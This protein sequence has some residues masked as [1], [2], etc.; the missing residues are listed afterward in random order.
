MRHLKPFFLITDTGFIVYWLITL[1]GWLP[2][3]YLYQGYHDPLLVAWNWSFLPLDLLVSATGLGS[4][5]LHRRGDPRW[6]SLA[7]LSLS[8]TLCSGLQAIAF[9]ALRGDFDLAWWLPNLYLLL[10]PLAFIPALIG[11]PSRRFAQL[12]ACLRAPR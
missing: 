9:W 2:E 4:L 6:A 10:Y 5:W 8:L 1:L 12:R 11:G 7:L 3:S